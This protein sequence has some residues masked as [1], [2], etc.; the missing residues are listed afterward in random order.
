VVAGAVPNG[1]DRL[2]TEMS[3]LATFVLSEITSFSLSLI[4]GYFHPPIVLI[5]TFMSLIMTIFIRLFPC[6][7]WSP[8]PVESLV[9]APSSPRVA[10][11]GSL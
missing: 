3:R 1:W 8:I 9:F 10:P 2:H 7:K 11:S 5:V 4:I 6:L